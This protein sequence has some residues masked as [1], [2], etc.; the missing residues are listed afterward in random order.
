MN[1]NSKI[2]AAM[3]YVEGRAPVRLF[4]SA[5]IMLY[6]A[7]LHEAF[8]PPRTDAHGRAEVLNWLFWQMSG[9]GPMT[10]NYGHFMVYAP[11]DKG[12]ARDYG[13]ARY[14]MEVQRCCSVL[15]NRLASVNSDDSS[16]YLV[17]NTYSVADMACF[18]WVHQLLVGYNHVL[19]GSESE[20][21]AMTTTADFLS[22]NSEQYPHLM[23]WH[24]AIEGRLAVKR[25]LLVCP[26]S[27]KFG[28]KP[29][30]HPDWVDVRVTT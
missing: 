26:F 9:Q 15:E 2:P 20:S 16:A 25:G 4:E 19:E 23:R 8:I 1:P 14:G 18:P 12:A 29:W 3:H 13:V 27:N 5:S 17:N 21:S 11:D 28:T 24:D 22:I 10:G 30:M 7:E 6:L